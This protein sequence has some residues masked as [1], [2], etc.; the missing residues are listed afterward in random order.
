MRERRHDRPNAIA[1]PE[2][3]STACESRLEEIRQTPI[4]QP[5]VGLLADAMT[6]IL[7]GEEVIG[8]PR[9]LQ[10]PADH[11]QVLRR[12]IGI[13]H[14]LDDEQLALDSVDEM[15]G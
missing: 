7:E 2:R 8:D 4:Q 3:A 9:G 1:L 10:G 5:P 12:D 13:A 15:D 6:L 11:R 14:A